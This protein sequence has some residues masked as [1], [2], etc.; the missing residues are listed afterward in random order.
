[1][2]SGSTELNAPYQ[3]KEQVSSSKSRYI[4]LLLVL[5]GVLMSV[6]DGSVVSIAL[7]T[8]TEYF[9]VSI[10]QSQMIMTAYLVTITSLLLIFGRVAE[11]VG[12]AKLFFLGIALFTASSLACGISSS[13]E[14]LVLCRIF[15][16]T[17]GAMMFSISAAIIFLAF[18][19]SEQGRA[20]GYIGS[21]VAIGSILGPTLG[22]FIVD[23][24]GWSYV[25]LINVPI[26]LVQMLLSTRYLRIE[27][28]RSSCLEVDWIGA[29]TL[30]ALIVSLMA[31][32]GQLSYGLAITPAILILAMIFV[33]TLA[34]FIINESRQKSPLLDLSIFRYRMFVLPSISLILFF[35]ANLMVSV[36]GPFYFE[37]VRGY[38]ASQ[39][40]LIY[41]I[42]PSIMVIG[43]PLGGTIYDKHRF[44]YLAA[45][46]MSIMAFSMIMLGYLAM[47]VTT[48]IRMLL[49]CFF[50]M[51]IGGAFFQSPNNTELMRALP[52]SKINIASSFT[53]T[54]RNLGMAL[55]VSLSGLLV[56]LQM[57]QAGHYGTI[58][59]AEPLL[60]ASSISRVML[61]AGGLCIISAMVATY[62]GMCM[63]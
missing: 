52:I 47:N 45:F 34:G 58:S 42:I 25:F 18:P 54:I 63:K 14:M 9:H 59:E 62:R 29:M 31:L 8:I 1:M 24:L 27:E 40:G 61:I 10:A 22:G 43:A 39:V 4:V 13:L 3:D 2:G 36:L 15:Q 28:K 50:F 46:G 57:A 33:L 37:G 7:P 41:L 12:K 23:L 60:L 20:M 55:G 56:S 6:L 38:T 53:A 11:Y 32:L 21:T 16:A 48:D 19:K 51:G 35:V 30:I 49:V 17:G 5:T 44:R 26:G